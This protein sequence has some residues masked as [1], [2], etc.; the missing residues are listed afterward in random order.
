M[1]SFLGD[2]TLSFVGRGLDVM[3]RR[4]SVLAS[5]VANLDTPGFKPK[6]VQFKRALDGAKGTG[7][8]GVAKTTAGHL[9][10]SGMGPGGIPT[11][12][13]MDKRPGLDGNAVDLD[14][15]MARIGQNAIAYQAGTRAVTKKL[16]LLKYA[17]SEGG[18]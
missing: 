13:V 17:A 16:A 4:Q 7:A 9:A 8:I 6:D 12:E 5:N 2:H 1:S 15:Q 14:T 3:L 11:E 18:I 10:P